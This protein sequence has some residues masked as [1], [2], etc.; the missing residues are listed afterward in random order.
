MVW[1]RRCSIPLDG[2]GTWSTV[3]GTAHISAITTGPP[4][5]EDGPAAI[6]IAGEV[7]GRRG[8]YR[9][10]DLMETWSLLSASPYGIYDHIRTMAAD[11]DEPGRVYVGFAGSGVVE[12]R[13]E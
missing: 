1:A 4:V 13:F 3:G 7:D 10:D 11:P 8:V 12:G 9:S 2:G 6:Y 5:E